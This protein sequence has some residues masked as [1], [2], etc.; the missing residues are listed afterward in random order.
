MMVWLVRGNE[1]NILV[2]SGF[3]RD[4]FIEKTARGFRLVGS[5]C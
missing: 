3:Y 4:Y 5:I 1:H 2:D